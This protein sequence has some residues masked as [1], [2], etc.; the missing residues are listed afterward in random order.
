MKM[1]LDLKHVKT[2]IVE[3]NSHTMKLVRTILTGIGVG[4]VFTAVD[5][6]DAL[7]F[8][9]EAGELIN[10]IVCD[11]NMPRMTGI[12][13]LHEV[14]KIHPDMPF[15]MITA[16]ATAESVKTARE[17]GVDAYV[18]KPFSPQTLEEKI[19]S[20]ARRVAIE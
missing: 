16:R 1:D 2:L 14:K 12:E 10:F 8:I 19:V 3:D 11:W 5:G 15:L 20:L 6:E 4:Q 7:K 18:A 13:L 17:A 9:K